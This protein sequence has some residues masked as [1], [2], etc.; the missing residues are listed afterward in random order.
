LPPDAERHDPAH[1]ARMREEFLDYLGRGY[2]VT[3]F[4]QDSE[5]ELYVLEKM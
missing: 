5:P 1:Q 2:V 4:R 3:G